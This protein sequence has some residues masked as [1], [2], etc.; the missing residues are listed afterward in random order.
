MI[1]KQ[2][3]IPALDTTIGTI[4]LGCMGMSWGT[5]ADLDAAPATTGS[6]Y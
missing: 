2:R 4:G 6:R 1:M 5:L 3:T